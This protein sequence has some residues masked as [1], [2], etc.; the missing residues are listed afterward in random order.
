[1]SRLT[2]CD[3]LK[4]IVQRFLSQLE[5]LY[6]LMKSVLKMPKTSAFEHERASVV[7]QLLEYLLSDCSI[8][9]RKNMLYRYSLSIIFNF[10]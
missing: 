6:D 10:G 2:A 4:E 7:I 5:N 9:R 8:G 1:M 3:T